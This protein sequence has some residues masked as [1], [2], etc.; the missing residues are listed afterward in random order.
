MIQIQVDPREALTYLQRIRS[1]APKVMAKV[2]ND[3]ANEV[4]KAQ[5]LELRRTMTINPGRLTFVER[6]IKRTAEDKAT[7]QKLAASVRIEGSENRK[8]GSG[9][10]LSRHVN[11]TTHTMRGDPFFIPSKELRPGAHDVAPRSMYPK[12]LRLY[13][14]KGITGTLSGST[15]GKRRKVAGLDKATVGELKRLG[16]GGTFIVGKG[17][18]WSIVQRVGFGS[19][20]DS[21]RTLWFLRPQVRLTKRFQFEEVARKTVD[22]TWAKLIARGIADVERDARR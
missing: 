7:P 3:V 17:K 1:D 19:G 21:L 18:S 10:V 11:P 14:M 9:D 16:L 6:L 2:L 12:A 20:R 22:R 8:K 4:Q 13:D 5:R 15:K